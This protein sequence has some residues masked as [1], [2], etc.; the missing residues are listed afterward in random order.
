MQDAI[1]LWKGLNTHPNR[2]A[3]AGPRRVRLGAPHTPSAT[4][5]GPGVSLDVAGR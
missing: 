1:L 2:G 5:F 3:E 4:Q